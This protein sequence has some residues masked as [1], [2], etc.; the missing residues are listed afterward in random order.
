MSDQTRKKAL[1]ISFVLSGIWIGLV[2]VCALC[3]DILPLPGFDRIDWDHMAAP[4]GTCVQNSVQ[5]YNQGRAPRTIFYLMG[6]DTLGRDIL[7]RLIFGARIS[8]AIGLSVPLTGLLVGTGFGMVAG[9]YKGKADNII[10]AVMDTV[11]AFPG[12]IL[13]LAITYTIG[14]GLKNLIFAMGILVTPS[15]SRIARANTIKFVE[16]DFVPASKMMGH[17]DLYI[18]VHEL[19]P[20]VIVPVALYALMIVGY[21]ITA[22]GV[23]SFLGFGIPE[24]FPSWGKMIAEGKDLLDQ[25]PFISLIPS[26]IMFLTILSFN[27]LGDC[28]REH[29][30]TKEA[31]L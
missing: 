30:E 20:N 15:F 23:L 14:P 4:P 11:L 5:E 28:L 24:P 25:A 16:Q 9:F 3:A 8:L 17:S 27:L 26:F 19:L 13:L 1:R 7:T 21:I 2:I 18:M 10:M 12:I 31:Q 29:I 6:T 22:E